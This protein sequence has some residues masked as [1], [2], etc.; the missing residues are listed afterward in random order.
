MRQEDCLMKRFEFGIAHRVL[1]G[2]TH[3]GKVGMARHAGYVITYKM[4]G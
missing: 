2:R 1:L 3:Q 4:L